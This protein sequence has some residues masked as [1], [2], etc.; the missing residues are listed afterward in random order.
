MAVRESSR[1]RHEDARLSAFLDD[2][3]PEAEALEVTRHLSRCD[4]CLSEL[5]DVRRARAA[6]RRLPNV[7][8]PPALFL[9]AEFVAST[10]TAAGWPLRIRL[11]AAAMVGS[12]ALGGAAFAAGGSPDGTVSPPVEL[13]VVDHVLRVG[14]GPVLTPVDLTPSAG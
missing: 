1:S 10:A 12:A 6:L 7:D 13:F 4:R 8:P 9:D 5:E 2:E 11:L 14:G 3:L